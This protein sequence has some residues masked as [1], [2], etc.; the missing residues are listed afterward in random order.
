MFDK[1]YE[2]YFTDGDNVDF[3][4][5]GEWDNIDCHSDSVPS[6]VLDIKIINYINNNHNGCHVV[7]IDKDRN[8]Y[9]VEL[10]NGLELV[11]DNNFDF[12]RYDD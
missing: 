9:N 11:F 3:D 8:D 2:V 10:N 1:T 4:K 7:E 5:N 6:T 12:E